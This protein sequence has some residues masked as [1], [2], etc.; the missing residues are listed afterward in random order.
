MNTK[1]VTTGLCF[2]VLGTL[3]S[4]TLRSTNPTSTNIYYQPYSVDYAVNNGSNPGDTDTDF[5]HDSL[6]GYGG[7]NVY[8][9]KDGL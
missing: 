7:I 1:I 3:T 5:R 9:Y 4:C 8:D 6:V 2:I